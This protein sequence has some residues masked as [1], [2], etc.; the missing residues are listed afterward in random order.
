MRD[1]YWPKAVSYSLLLHVVL[2][3][4]IA[5]VVTVLPAKPPPAYMVIDLTALGGGGSS[6]SQASPATAPAAQASAPAQS[7]SIAAAIK[8]PEPVPPLIEPEVP[9]MP[10][11]Q[12]ASTGVTVSTP[13][14]A[15][16]A[17]AGGGNANG[18]SNGGGAGTGVGN[19][20]G[21]GVGVGS[22]SGSGTG[23]GAGTG[24][25]SGEGLESVIQAF[26]NR[27]EKSKEYP[28]MARRQGQQGVV[29]LM[30]ELSASG[31]LGRVNVEQ[32]SGHKLL[33]NAA[34][35]AVKRATPFNHGLGRSV[36]LKIPLRYRLVSG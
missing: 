22:G 13:T 33:D 27:L 2:V 19:G 7:A 11:V 20:S 18:T 4:G 5:L 35:A 36:L 26:L 8:Q 6:P 17:V 1:T 12:P 16:P 30:V 14:T 28:Y 25:G 3:L 34:L 23:S 10:A 31:V 9:I 15:V 24:T 21:T 32:S 29:V